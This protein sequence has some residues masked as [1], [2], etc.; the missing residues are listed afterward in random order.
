M[1]SNAISELNELTLRRGFAANTATK[2]NAKGDLNGPL[3]YTVNYNFFRWVF[4]HYF[5]STMRKERG[6]ERLALPIHR[7]EIKR[8]IHRDEME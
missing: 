7:A 2:L 8:K 3:C 1:A 6:R 4:L 5:S